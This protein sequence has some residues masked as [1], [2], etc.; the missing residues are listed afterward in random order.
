M[1]A[2][3]TPYRTLL[4]RALQLK[5]PRCGKGRLY[6]SWLKMNADCPECGLDIRH[7][8]GFYLGSIYVNYGLTAV[9]TTIIFFFGY[10]RGV[11]DGWLLAGLAVFCVVF[12]LLIF[13]HARGVWL[14]FDQYWDPQENKQSELHLA[15]RALP[16]AQRNGR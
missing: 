4:F 7:E 13:R 16:V 5:C 8:P 9:L 12:P 14:A 15:E 10:S 6:Q 3:R 11:P 1:A 2:P